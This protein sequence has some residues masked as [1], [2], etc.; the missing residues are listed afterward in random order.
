MSQFLGGALSV[1][2]LPRSL[3]ESGMTF[4]LWLA[5]A[6]E[7]DSGELTAFGLHNFHLLA[8][9][10]PHTKTFY[11]ESFEGTKC[12]SNSQSRELMVCL[13]IS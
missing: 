11:L 1:S 13:V 6:R 10:F 8:S 5:V 7:L 4:D 2:A 3:E 9:Q 12:L